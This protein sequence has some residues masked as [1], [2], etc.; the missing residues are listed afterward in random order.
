MLKEGFFNTYKSSNHNNN[1]F[2]L[3]QQKVIYP[4]EYIDD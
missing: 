3:L 2:I 4:C 1:K